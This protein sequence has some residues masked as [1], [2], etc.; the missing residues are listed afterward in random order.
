MAVR[1]PYCHFSIEL[2]GAH[3]GK[4]SP[5]C[6]A[7][8][9][10]FM[11]MISEDASIPPLVGELP[12]DAPSHGSLAGATVPPAKIAHQAMQASNV[13]A[14]PV[15]TM[16]PPPAPAPVGLSGP[17]G[18]LPPRTV[19]KD[20]LQPSG[21]TLTGTL[22]GYELLQKLGEGG[23]GA[24]YLARQVSL[25]RHVALKVLSP[26]LASD[27]QFVARFTREAYA[28][29]Q[30]THHNVVQIHDIGVERD[31]NFFSME[32]VEG[33]TLEKIV[34]SEGKLDPEAAVGYVLQAARGLRFA[35]E[36][37]LIHRD[38]KPDNLLLNDQGIVKVADLGLVKQAGHTETIAKSAPAGAGAPPGKTQ[39]NVSMGT[40]AYMPPEQARDAAHVDQR[41]DIYSLGCTLYDL[42]TGAPPFKGKTAVEM[43]SKHQTEPVTPPDRIARH[44]SPELST[45]VMKMMA[46]KPEERYQ[47]MAEV[48][49]TLERILGVE[50][51][52]TFSPKDEHVRALEGAAA[53]FN[54]AKFAKIRRYSTLGFLGACMG[55][56]VI[57]ALPQVGHPLFAGGL[58]GFAVLTTL[59][60][61]ALLG[62]TRKTHLFS[63]VRQFAFGARL[64]DW[65]KVLAGFAVLILLLV[66]F[67]L[68]WVWLG[69]AVVSALA[70]AVFHFTIDRLV[71]KERDTPVTKLEAMLKNMRLRGLDET[72]LRQFVCKYSGNYWEE[73][74]E[75]LFGYEAKRAARRSWGK[76]ERGRNR[77]RFAPWRDVI[78][79]WIDRREIARREERERKLL[80]RLEA[81]ALAAKGMDQASANRQ[82]KKAAERLV[83]KAS[84]VKAESER[85]M[86][87]TALPT[88]SGRSFVPVSW[89]DGFGENEPRGKSRPGLDGEDRV[90]ESYLKRRYGSVWDVILGPGPRIVVGAA[91]L[92][93]FALWLRQSGG[94]EVRDGQNLVTASDAVEKVKQGKI[95]TAKD[96]QLNVKAKDERPLRLGLIPDLIEDIVG[97]FN[98]G[99]AG[100]LLLLSGFFHGKRLGL[101]LIAAT[102]LILLGATLP[103]PVLQNSPWIAA[104]VG[105][106][107]G[108]LGIV[109]FRRTDA[110]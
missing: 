69:F 57:C 44:V 76:G 60:Y 80:A 102:I 14:P 9:R 73:M 105:V 88:S 43:I 93:L 62:V 49:E 81:K 96:L 74:Y 109:I 34:H 32:L 47:T 10:R 77:P 52:K 75:A 78:I 104:G 50:S 30:L 99:I 8:Q 41:A 20:D 72:A 4:F 17:P 19:V 66:A 79:D 11:L 51:S 83:D 21:P 22:G 35:H 46:K 31:V 3:A 26:Q 40:P 12:A 91:L 2:K 97:N 65:L 7:C 90:H 36:H 13:T 100:G 94:V 45:V 64:A 29:A 5:K 27:P 108:L 38:V 25:D 1:C 23:M 92:C 59:F 68:H 54:S 6:P 98:G 16:P 42:L 89:A 56:A 37:G 48:V 67:K 107:I 63:R 86:M 87:T 82:A 106:G 70:A 33:K 103:V 95:Q 39:L 85:R 53:E 110:E 71:T 28:A 84:R 15:A 24:V 101:T 55:G 58:V 61:Q 18:D